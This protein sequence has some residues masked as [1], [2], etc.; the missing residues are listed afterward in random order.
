MPNNIYWHN[1]PNQYFM[2]TFIRKKKHNNRLKMFRITS[3]QFMPG[4]EVEHRRSCLKKR[5]SCLKRWLNSG[6]GPS[7][8]SMRLFFYQTTN[9]CF[10]IFSETW[11]PHGDLEGGKPDFQTCQIDSVRMPIGKAGGGFNLVDMWECVFLDQTSFDTTLVYH[12]CKY[13]YTYIC[14]LL[15]NI[16]R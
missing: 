7:L 11:R 13:I 16:H 9:Q 14:V 12:F 6:G 8:K 5:R 3:T 1:I 2:H 15:A 4:V 10:F